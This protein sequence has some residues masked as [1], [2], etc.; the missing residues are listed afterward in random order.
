MKLR[1]RPICGADGI[2]KARL[3][4]AFTFA[5]VLA[6][7]LFMAIVIPVAMQGVQLANRT[8]VAAQRKTMA[9]Q[10][11]NWQLEELIGTTNWVNS[12][13][14][15]TFDRTSM[16]TGQAPVSTQSWSDYRWRL[17]NQPWAESAG[18]KLVTIEVTYRVQNQDYTVQLS[19]LAPDPN[20]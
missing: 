3:D 10:L 19:T 11:A 8:G 6:A 16:N 12:G 4:A 15:G 17:L 14:G 1:T 2:R 5:E 18:M 20:Q 13:Q 7:L 9:I